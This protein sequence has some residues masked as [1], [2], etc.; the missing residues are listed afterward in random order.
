VQAEVRDPSI[1]DGR[2]RTAA[3]AVPIAARTGSTAAG[4]VLVTG[5]QLL[6]GLDRRLREA[7]E[8]R[9]LIG[10]AVGFFLLAEP[11]DRRQMWADVPME[12]FQHLLWR[13]ADSP[14]S[15]G[16]VGYRPIAQEGYKPPKLLRQLR[17]IE[18]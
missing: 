13:R 5:G 3:E 4:R 7:S 8:K 2:M 9:S 14:A 17:C 6:L 1:L 10:I 11:I 16:V 18:R 12:R 15:L